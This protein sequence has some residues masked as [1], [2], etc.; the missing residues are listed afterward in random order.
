MKRKEQRRSGLATKKPQYASRITAQQDEEPGRLGA[1]L[2]AH[3][4]GRVSP[5]SNVL[6][7]SYDFKIYPPSCLTTNRQNCESRMSSTQ[8]RMLALDMTTSVPGASAGS[9]RCRS[10]NL[11]I[12]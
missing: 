8:A 4:H 6:Q 2:S 11:T 12:V 10:R 9:F 7:A 5:Q 1:Q 3:T